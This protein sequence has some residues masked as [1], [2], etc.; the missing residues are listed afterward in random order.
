MDQSATADVG[1]AP[2]Y[3][4]DPRLESLIGPGGLFEVE[5][6]TVDGV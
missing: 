3:R 6:V 2:V 1:V 4:D 5:A